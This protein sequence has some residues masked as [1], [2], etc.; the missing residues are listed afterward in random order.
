MNCPHCRVAIHDN[1]QQR[2][3]L[4]VDRDGS[5][6]LEKHRCPNCKR[7]ILFLV[8]GQGNPRDASQIA[9]PVRHL[10]VWPNGSS[11]DPVPDEVPKAIAEDYIEACAVLKASPKAS[12]ALSRRCLQNLL[13]D[14]AQIKHSDLSNEIQEVLDS[15]GLPSELADSID[16]IRNIGNFAAH[17]IKSKNSGEVVAVELGEAEWNLDVLEE[18]FDHYYVKPEKIRAKRAALNAKLADAG[19]PPMK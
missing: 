19:K 10:L 16:H 17:P 2:I 3:F 5:W 15:G 13:R 7:F 14:T 4:Q 9:N 11:R 12:A 1:T 8:N 18:L 6:V